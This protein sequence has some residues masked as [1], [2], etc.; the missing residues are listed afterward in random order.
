M[1]SVPI[2]GLILHVCVKAGDLHLGLEHW[3]VYVHVII[4]LCNM[5]MHFSYST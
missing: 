3:F 5:H 4:S 2:S 1:G